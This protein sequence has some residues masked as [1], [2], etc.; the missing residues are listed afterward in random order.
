MGSRFSLCL[1]LNKK[2]MVQENKYDYQS[3]NQVLNHIP[4]I[5]HILLESENENP[6]QVG[7]IWNEV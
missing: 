5:P 3:Y 1:G 2:N 4:A 6:S 7:T